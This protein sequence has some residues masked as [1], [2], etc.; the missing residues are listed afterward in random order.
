[1]DTMARHQSSRATTTM[2]VSVCNLATLCRRR[3]RWP[4]RLHTARVRRIVRGYKPPPVP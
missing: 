2:T 1:M 4:A 3:T